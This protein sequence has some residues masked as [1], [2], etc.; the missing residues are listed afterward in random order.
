MKLIQCELCDE[1]FNPHSREKKEA[2]GKFRHCPSCAEETAVKHLG[3]GDGCGKQSSIQV[4]AFETK[5]DR[6]NYA[7]YWAGAT[8]MGTGKNSHMSYLPSPIQQ[9]FRKIAEHGGNTNHKG[10]ND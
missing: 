7:R 2:G 3:V 5:E 6:Q 4:L 9:K 1:L 10:K 8:G